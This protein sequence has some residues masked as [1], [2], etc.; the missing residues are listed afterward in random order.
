MNKAILR[1]SVCAALLVL[2]VL[3]GAC[4]DSDDD[5]VG[6]ETPPPFGDP[7]TPQPTI[8]GVTPVFTGTAAVTVT[9]G[10]TTLELKPAICNADAAGDWLIVVAPQ[11]PE[12]KDRFS[13]LAGSHPQIEN[14]DA[15][16]VAGGGVIAPESY[17]IS[18]S[19]SGQ[20]VVVAEPDTTV[21]LA[22]DLKSGTVE[23]KTADGADIRAS[24]TC[25]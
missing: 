10:E 9:L 24:F 25:G 5:P 21:T 16:S 7:R 22:A 2:G 11:D 23:G 13:L 1:I 4:G 17:V 8:E 20:A 6:G 12:L 18:G 14:P 19:I 3:S 15:E